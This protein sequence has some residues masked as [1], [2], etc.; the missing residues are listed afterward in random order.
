MSSPYTY[1]LTDSVSNRIGGI[2]T[3]EK[4]GQPTSLGIMIHSFSYMFIIR[5]MMEK[6]NLAGCEKPYTAKD[7]WIASSIGGLMFATISS[8]FFYNLINE[9]SSRL[10]INTVDNDGCQNIQGLLLHTAAFIVATRILMY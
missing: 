5:I 9:L 3:I 2:R 10:G 4:S 8:P 1:T 6:R 7:K